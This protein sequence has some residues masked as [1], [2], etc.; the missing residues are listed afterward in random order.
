M[1]YI[2]VGNNGTA[3]YGNMGQGSYFQTLEG[4]KET[5]A[6]AAT[7]NKQEMFIFKKVFSVKTEAP[8]V[9][10]TEIK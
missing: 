9:I 2:V 8:P 4:A 10:V 1:N 7:T 3:Y 6:W 5:A